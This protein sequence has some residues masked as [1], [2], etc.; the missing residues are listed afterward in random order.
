MT[1]KISGNVSGLKKNQIMQLEELYEMNV[2]KGQFV[3][4]EIIEIL[5]NLSL[6]VGREIAIYMN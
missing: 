1:R 5:A 3:S 6:A 2:D 4:P